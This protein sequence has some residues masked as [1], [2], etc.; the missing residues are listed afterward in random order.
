M[1]LKSSIQAPNKKKNYEQTWF[2]PLLHHPKSPILFYYYFLPTTQATLIQKHWKLKTNIFFLQ[3]DHFVPPATS[4]G[5]CINRQRKIKRLSV[6]AHRNGSFYANLH[7]T[8]VTQPC[9]VKTLIID[10]YKF[11][12]ISSE[13]IRSCK[14]V[15]KRNNPINFLY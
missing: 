10:I 2:Y 11:V 6:E 3:I 8:N 1:V 5:T 9:H 4:I 15:L 14:C 7:M 13:R 12:K